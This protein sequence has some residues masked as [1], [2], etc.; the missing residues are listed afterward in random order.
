MMVKTLIGNVRG[1]QG[2]IGPQGSQGEVG[3]AGKTMYLHK[4]IFYNEGGQ[5]IFLDIV[6]SESTPYT[7]S[8]VRNAN[9]YLN[10][11][12]NIC[13]K[14]SNYTLKSIIISKI[15]TNDDYLYLDDWITGN[16]YDTI[17]NATDTVV[18][19]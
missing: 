9:Q 8:T 15:D 18:E 3:P 14:E 17:F 6:N 4:I 5:Q 1:P 16:A 12:S 10:A 7:F 13:V 11:F 2:E 19:L